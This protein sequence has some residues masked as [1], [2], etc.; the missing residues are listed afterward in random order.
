MGDS[1]LNPRTGKKQRIGRLYQVHANKRQEIQQ[2]MAG[3]IAATTG[4]RDVRTGD[5]LCTI[6]APLV[7]ESLF[8]PTPVI[9]MA[10]EAKRS[11]ELDKLGIALH[12]LQLQDPSFKVQTDQVM[13]QTLI[14]GMG[15]LHLDIIIDRLKEEFKL[16]VNVGCLLYTS[17]SPRDRQ[18]SRM[19]SSA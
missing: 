16:A 13:G 7:L 1:I 8:V 6:K 11:D 10:I 18:K 4:L 9:S 19:P 14:L 12:K 3:D 2:V 5:T 17:P 15:E